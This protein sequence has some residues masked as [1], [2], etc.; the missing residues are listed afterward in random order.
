MGILKAPCKFFPQGLLFLLDVRGESMCA[1]INESTSNMKPYA[2]A[3][4][5]E[6]IRRPHGHRLGRQVRRQS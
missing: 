3:E 1:T 2:Y 6:E 5:Y 4:T